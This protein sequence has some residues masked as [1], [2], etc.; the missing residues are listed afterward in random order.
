[1]GNLYQL[2]SY[3]QTSMVVY[4]LLTVLHQMT[5]TDTSNSLILSRKILH[6]II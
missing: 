1:M 6:S 2:D 5:K 4:V 3:T